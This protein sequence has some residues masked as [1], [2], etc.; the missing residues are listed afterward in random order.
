MLLESSHMGNPP[1]LRILV[2]AVAA[3]AAAT[4]CWRCMRSSRC[5]C[6]R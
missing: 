5:C 1:T 2:V 4:D 3:D 6:S